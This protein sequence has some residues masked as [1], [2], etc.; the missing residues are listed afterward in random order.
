MYRIFRYDNI[1]RQTTNKSGFVFVEILISIALISIVFMTLLSMGVS[2]LSISSSMQ[3]QTQAD[4][5]VKEGFESV[6]NFR[7]GTIWATNGLGVVST[8]SANPYHLVDD[9]NNWTLASGEETVNG[10]ARRIVFDRVSRNPSTQDIESAYNPANDDPDTRM[11]TVTVSW[12]G[13]TLQVVSYLTNW[14]DD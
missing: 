1:K 2:A 9:S 11:V 6:R 8:G 4:S 13:K 7:D 5:L 10:F 3:K 14:K 12:A